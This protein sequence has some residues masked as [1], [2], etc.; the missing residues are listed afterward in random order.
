MNKVWISIV[1]ARYVLGREPFFRKRLQEVAGSHWMEAA[2][3]FGDPDN[4]ATRDEVVRRADEFLN[5]QP[6]VDIMAAMYGIHA[7]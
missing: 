4:P 5:T 1:A 3:Q 6:L 7:S 2:M